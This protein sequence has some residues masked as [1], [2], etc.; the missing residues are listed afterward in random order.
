MHSGE[1]ILGSRDSKYK[2][3]QVTWEWTWLIVFTLLP[4]L[5]PIKYE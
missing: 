5:L 3:P 2:G 1:S 4:G